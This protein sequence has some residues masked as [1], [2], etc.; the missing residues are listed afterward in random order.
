MKHSNF[1]G[2]PAMPRVA[3]RARGERVRFLNCNI[4]TRHQLLYLQQ[5]QH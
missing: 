1:C 2:A 5:P 3:A 4:P